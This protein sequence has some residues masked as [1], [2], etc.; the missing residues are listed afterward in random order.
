M[1]ESTKFGTPPYFIRV[2]DSKL[3]AESMP[4]EQYRWCS[5]DDKREQKYGVVTFL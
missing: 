1:Y 4:N 2:P 3:E 5:A